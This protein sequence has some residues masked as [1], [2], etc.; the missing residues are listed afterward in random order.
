MSL[1]PTEIFPGPRTLEQLYQPVQHQFSLLNHNAIDFQQAIHSLV[2]HTNDASPTS[3]FVARVRKTSDGHRFIPQAIK[4]G[5]RTILAQ[6]PLKKLSTETE[7]LISKHQVNYLQ[8]QDTAEAQAWLATS[9]FDFPSRKLIVLGITGTDGKTTVSNIAYHLLQAAKLKIGLLSTINAKVGDAEL[10][11]GL[12]VTTPEAPFVQFYLRKMVDQGLTH[13]ILETTSLGLA[14]HRVT[15]VDYDL[16]A[17]TN[18]TPEH[19]DYHGTMEEY[20]HSKGLLFANLKQHQSKPHQPKISVVNQDDDHVEYFANFPADQVLRY[21]LKE[22]KDTIDLTAEN[23]AFT[24][25]KT[26][27]DLI[28]QRS[29]HKIHITTNLLGR[30]NI[31]NSLAAFGLAQ[32]LQLNPTDIQ[33]GFANIQVFAGR[34][35]RIDQ[36]QDFL[37]IVD[38]AHTPFGLEQALKTARELT[39]GKIIIVFGS[40]AKRDPFKRP[41][42]GKLAH[43]LA[44]FTFITAE[45]PRDEPLEKISEEIAQGVRLAGGLEGTTF[46]QIA[47]R[48]RAIYQACLKA[49][50]GDLVITCGKGHEQSLCFGT[51]EY[52]WD[53]RQAMRTA[54]DCL[55]Q[56]QPMPDFGLPTWNQAEAPK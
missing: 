35:E 7:Q 4:N 56:N 9:W 33:Q 30:F 47:D 28:D 22:T 31:Y 48:A 45:D 21:S 41:F 54:L 27:F 13:C 49:A 34:M 43:Q 55:L 40:A 10:D 46:W 12:H 2:E 16:A 18:L 23:I 19:L 3:C 5:C 39:K 26:T 38:F 37:A 52:P 25:S 11:T 42:M 20:R 14:Q 6:L 8:V 44:D 32:G 29:K 15:G 17:I 36:G 53:D 1:H 24:P 51:T 50:P